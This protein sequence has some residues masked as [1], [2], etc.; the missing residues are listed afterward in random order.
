MKRRRCCLHI[1]VAPAHFKTDGAFLEVMILMH[2]KRQRLQRDFSRANRWW[3]CLYNKWRGAE[4]SAVWH[5]MRNPRVLPNLVTIY[6]KEVSLVSNSTDEGNN[7]SLAKVLSG[8]ETMGGK[9]NGKPLPSQTQLAFPNSKSAKWQR[10][11]RNINKILKFALCVY[12]R[13]GKRY[14]ESLH[15]VI[16]VSIVW[17]QIWTE[18]NSRQAGKTNNKGQLFLH[19]SHPVSVA[20]QMERFLNTLDLS[21]VSI[22]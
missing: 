10:R 14:S 21:S 1:K 15:K 5:W 11:T 6:D 2:K 16:H 18:W 7:R 8:S 20:R 13:S 4:S 3:L 22:W 19:W 12:L 9:N 17:S